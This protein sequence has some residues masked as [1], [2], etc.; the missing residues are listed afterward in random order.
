VQGFRIVQAN[1]VNSIFGYAEK[2]TGH[3]HLFRS[4]SL[5]GRGSTK[6]AVVRVGNGGGFVRPANAEKRFCNRCSR[7]SVTFPYK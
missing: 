2:L 6:Y 3:V 5:Q 4:R 1:N 7:L